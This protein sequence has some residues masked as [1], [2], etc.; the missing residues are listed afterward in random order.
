VVNSLLL[1]VVANDHRK[2]T[3]LDRFFL[4]VFENVAYGEP[5]RTSTPSRRLFSE[6]SDQQKGFAKDTHFAPAFETHP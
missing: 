2:P 1:R 3:W 4:D 5:T 6:I